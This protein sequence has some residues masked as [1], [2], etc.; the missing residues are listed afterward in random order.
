[1]ARGILT[2]SHGL[3]VTHAAGSHRL[4]DQR[5]SHAESSESRRCWEL[6]LS[7]ERSRPRSRWRFWCTSC[8][9]VRHSEAST[10]RQSTQSNDSDAKLDSKHHQNQSGRQ[11]HQLRFMI[12][13]VMG[14]GPRAEQTLLE[15]RSVCTPMTRN[16]YESAVNESLLFGLQHVHH[17]HTIADIGRALV[18]RTSCTWLVCST[19]IAQTCSPP[20][21]IAGQLS[22]N[23]LA[24]DST[25]SWSCE[26]VAVAR[27]TRSLC[28][29][30][31]PPNMPPRAA[32]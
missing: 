23:Q 32:I 25:L 8:R 26:G 19:I 30:Q 7:D 21:W 2:A 6:S 10:W 3:D 16:S 11:T 27:R 24:I 17:P 9:K 14:R 31:L 15:L 29:R 4:E 28:G 1:M 5:D 22:G 13:H 20:F 18:V 12:N